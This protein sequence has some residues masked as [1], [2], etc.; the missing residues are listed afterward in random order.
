MLDAPPLDTTVEETPTG[1]HAIAC[2]RCPYAGAMTTRSAAIAAAWTH[3][4]THDRNPQRG[5]RRP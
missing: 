4:D 1:L 3:H 5:P 2:H